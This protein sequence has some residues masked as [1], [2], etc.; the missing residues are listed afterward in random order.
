M[1]NDV[2]F[3]YQIKSINIHGSLPHKDYFKRIESATGLSISQVYNKVNRLIELGWLR[4]RRTDYSLCSYDLLWSY[5][6]INLQASKRVLFKIDTETELWRLKDRIIY[7][8]WIFNKKKQ[9]FI[10]FKKLLNDPYYIPKKQ[11]RR[12]DTEGSPIMIEDIINDRD[13][14][15]FVEKN[16]NDEFLNTLEEAMT[17]EAN[18]TRANLDTNIS[19]LSFAVLLG[20]SSASQGIKLQQSLVKCGLIKEIIKRQVIFTNI[21][22]AIRYKNGKSRYNYKSSIYHVPNTC[23]FVKQLT[24]VLVPFNNIPGTINYKFDILQC[25]TY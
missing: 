15:E 11:Y 9:T 16:L 24:N 2:L 22:E 8:E 7:E 3:W 6:G 23:T 5:F 17:G 1:I 18:K 19:A 20:Y 14:V 4:K 13:I 12:F 10:A 21:R 25:T